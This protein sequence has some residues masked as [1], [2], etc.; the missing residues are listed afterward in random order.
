MASTQQGV[1]QPRLRVSRTTDLVLSTTWQTVILN[2]VEPLNV[3]TFGKDPNSNNPLVHYDT[4]NSLF[5]FYEQY[6][7]N[8]NVTLYMKVTSTIVGT[9]VTL[10]YRMV[11]PN[12]GGAGV[13]TSFPF[14][15]SGGYADITY[16]AMKVGAVMNIE[17]PISMYLSNSIRNNGV[18]F[19]LRLSDTLL[20]VGNITVNNTAVLIQQ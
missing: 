7:V 11:V 19:Q 10:Q 17:R 3:N 15:T 4:A 8:Y 13:D 16:V 2:G 12:G 14:P 18:R 20:G 6:D 9:G 5:R 1:N